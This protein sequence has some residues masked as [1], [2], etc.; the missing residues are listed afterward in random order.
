MGNLRL[1]GMNK[2]APRIAPRGSEN[3]YNGSG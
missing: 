1:K 3:V 2:K